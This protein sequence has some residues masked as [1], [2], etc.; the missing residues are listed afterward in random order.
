[1]PGL[2]PK[3]GADKKAPAA[4]PAAAAPKPAAVEAAAEGFAI[5]ED[6][7]GGRPRGKGREHQAG[8]GGHRD[9]PDRA[10][11]APVDGEARR[12]KREFERRSGT[13]RGRE[14]SKGGR[15]AFG[16]GNVDQDALDAEKHP[17]EAKDVLEPTEQEQQ[18]AEES[19]PEPEVVPEPS[20]FTLDEFMQ[21]R[22]AARA[23]LQG[24][25]LVAD[26]APRQVDKAAF[27]N[28]E[29]KNDT[30]LDA[31]MPGNGKGSIGLKTAAA[32]AAAGATKKDQR[33]V[34]KA[35]VLD[36]GFKFQ[37]IQPDFDD[38]RE[39]GDRPER[40]DQRGGRGGGGP[41]EPRAPRPAGGGRGEGGGGGGAGR[42]GGA[43]SEGHGHGSS[44]KKDAAAPAAV[45]NVQDFPSL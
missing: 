28:L 25:G 13:G 38:R 40:G 34:G 22:E 26:K 7:R 5:K 14:V 32:G 12:P 19:T 16:F 11:G 27:G 33:S 18:P 15:G 45:F 29:P 37:A 24:L 39:R 35:T 20:V 1:M 17:N 21:K 8:R 2:P 44:G 3:A 23:K 31:Y 4:A 10:E 42:G 9:R 36:V 41:R 30:D 6:T 43:R